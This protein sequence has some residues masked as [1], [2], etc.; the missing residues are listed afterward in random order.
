M[1]IIRVRGPA[2]ICVRIIRAKVASCC[3]VCRDTS[4]LRRI[5]RN[6][7]PLWLTL[8]RTRWDRVPST[9]DTSRLR[10]INRNL[11][12]LWLTLAR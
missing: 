10:R 8:A 3:R 5:N 1:G 9:R 12:P 6:L 4:R 11:W 2:R 7:W